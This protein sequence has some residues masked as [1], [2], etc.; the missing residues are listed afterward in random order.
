MLDHSA[1]APHI[2]APARMDWSRLRILATTDLHAHIMPWDYQA[3]RASPAVGLARTASLIAA[4]RA[5]VACCL[6]VDNGDFLQGSPLGDAEA[7]REQGNGAGL[8]PMVAAMNAL[9]YDAATLGNHEFSQGLPFLLTSL[10]GAQ[11]PVVSANIARRLGA[12]ALEDETLVPPTLI[13]QRP[14]RD[15]DGVGHPLRIGI[16][17]LLPPQTPQWDQAKL[18]N[19]LFARD[20]LYAAAAHVPA[21][22][23]T[24]VDLV[25][26]LSHSGM[27]PSIALPW[28]ENASAA[29]AALPGIDAVVMGHTHLTF[30]STDHPVAPGID[31]VG[32]RL[33]GKP[34][35]MPGMFGSHLGVIDLDLQWEKGRWHLMG[36]Q[37][38][39][40]PIARRAASG[41][42]QAR[43]RS[44]PDIVALAE[45]AH[46]AT[47]RWARQPVGVS[48]VPWHSYFAM[49][50]ASPTVRLIARAQALQVRRTLQG[51]PF[52]HLP[53]LS[54]AAPFHAG[55]RAG[56][57]NYT[58]IAAGRLTLGHV[59]DLYPYPN[60]IAAL[61]VSGATLQEWLE[62]SFSQFRQILPGVQD[63]ELLDPDFPSF[64]F[65]AIEGLTWTVDLSSPARYDTKGDVICPR[66]NRICNLA[67]EGQGLG[68]DQPFV[69]AT[70]SYRSNGSSGFAGAGAQHIVLDGLHP[71]R[72]V[73]RRYIAEM[74]QMGPEGPPN[75]TFRPMP[76]T[77]VLFDSAPEA[78]VCLED[79]APLQADALG[80]T[81][82]GFRR[83]RL[84]L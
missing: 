81:P 29:L 16:I 8:H 23:A 45:P 54:A 17:G 34:A 56:P 4:A 74:G 13:L 43:T 68:P 6:L 79:L 80:L 18:G 65:D 35:V 67:F 1:T 5:E 52:G 42:L 70:N 48:L 2:F 30:P 26:A 51:G 84:H 63:V 37:S 50:S 82:K 15:A 24:G 12:T 25:L 78:A 77:R 38:A 69:L 71:S 11:F 28:M 57:E 20:M 44:A 21:L 22:R 49:V 19:T 72:D 83:F 7:L 58:H 75:W 32:G 14:L 40:R 27:G 60:T 53:V 10:A 33:W 47:R 64:N 36:G 9:R 55:G 73:L 31:R 39:L 59:F 46:K 62:R 3:N 61:L 66:A 76:G 41:R